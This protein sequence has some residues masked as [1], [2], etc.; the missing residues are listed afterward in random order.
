MKK[1][2]CSLK[3]DASTCFLLGR[4]TCL[5]EFFKQGQYQPLIH[6][7]EGIHLSLAM[8]TAKAATSNDNDGWPLQF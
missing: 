6:N 2:A 3:L 8:T 7:D 4:G 5:I 1:L